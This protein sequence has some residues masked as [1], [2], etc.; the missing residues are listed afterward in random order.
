MTDQVKTKVAGLTFLDGLTLVFIHAK[1]TKAIV[2][3]WW[4]VMAPLWIQVVLAGVV[5]SVAFAAMVAKKL[6]TN[7]LTGAPRKT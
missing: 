4:L 1:I 6:T 2:W 5:G 7:K 3:S